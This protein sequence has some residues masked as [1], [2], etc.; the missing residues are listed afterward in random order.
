MANVKSALELALEKADK[1]GVLSAEEKALMQDEAK[2][3]EIL[4]E[5]FQG[6]IDSNGLW[7]KFKGGKPELL[8]AA[9]INLIDTLG[10]NGMPEE[11][12]SKKKAI[13][14]I[15]TLKEQPNTVVIESSLQAIEVLKKEYEG[16]KEQ[17]VADLKKHIEGNPQLRMKQMRSPDGRTMQVAVSVEEAVKAKLDEYLPQ[18]EEQYAN[19]FSGIIEELKMQVQ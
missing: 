6:K 7:Q 10:I 17:I 2:I 19:D 16:M 15:E 1:I 9:Q 8:R 11:L 3:T 18:H 5:F 14:A 13:L 12:Q 4:R